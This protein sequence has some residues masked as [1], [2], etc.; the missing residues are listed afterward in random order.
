M[1]LPV[2][3]VNRTQEVFAEYTSFYEYEGWEPLAV[4]QV[5]SKVIYEDEETMFIYDAKPDLIVKASNVPVLPVDHKHSQRSGEVCPLSNQFLGYCWIL[6]VNNLCV[7]KIGFQ[8]TVP[9]EKKFVRP[10]LSYPES[11]INEWVDNTIWW[12]QMLKIF[13]SSN[14]WPADLTSCDKWDGCIFQEICISDPLVRDIKLHQT[15]EVTEPWDVARK[16]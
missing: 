4:E 3:E 14:Y 7:N 10:I 15:F 8:K 6:G 5:A 9:I 16:L 1:S 13:T 11:V 12:L 2:E